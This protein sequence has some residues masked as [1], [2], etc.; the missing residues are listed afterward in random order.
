M[1]YKEELYARQ[2]YQNLKKVFWKNSPSFLRFLGLTRQAGSEPAISIEGAGVH[3]HCKVSKATRSCLINCFNI[4]FTNTAY[5]GPEY[6]SEFEEN[7][8]KKATGRTFS[9]KDT[10]AA[11]SS[12]LHG[13]SLGELYNQLAFVDIEKRKLRALMA[14]LKAIHPALHDVQQCEIIEDYFS[15][16][17]LYIKNDNRGCSI[18]CVDYDHHMQYNFTWEEAAI[19]ETAEPDVMQMS[20]LI[21][22]WVVDAAAPSILAAEFPAIDFGSLAPYYEQGDGISG[23]FILSWDAIEQFYRQSTLEIKIDILSLIKQIR[24]KGFDKTLRAGQSL[25]TLI[26]SRSRH[27]GLRAG[28]PAITISFESYNFSPL[29]SAM[30]VEFGDTKLNFDQI[31]YNEQIENILIHLQ[32]HSID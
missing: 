13:Q 4:G 11:V 10:I 29:S 6:Y 8:Q 19:F 21:K 30:Q 9:Q 5:K 27:H 16:P 31:A 17:T 32:S 22:R 1:D 14:D 28:Q 15:L 12:W 23:E 25:Y 18:E 26:L 20:W 7:G 24:T 3:W 2:L